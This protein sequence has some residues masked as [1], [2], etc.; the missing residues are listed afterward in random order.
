MQSL[1]T[2]IHSH[3][4]VNR[5]LEEHISVG[6][7]FESIAELWGRFSELMAQTGAPE[8]SEENVPPAT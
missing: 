7:G 1:E 8:A 3:N 2:I 5:K 4:A 6:R